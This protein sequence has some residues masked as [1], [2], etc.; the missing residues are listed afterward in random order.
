MS[1]RLAGCELPRPYICVQCRTGES[2]SAL[3]LLPQTYSKSCVCDSNRARVMEVSFPCYCTSH[4]VCNPRLQKATRGT[5]Y[6]QASSLR[7]YCCV[8]G[9][10]HFDNITH[11]RIETSVPR[12]RGPADEQPTHV[13]WMV[14]RDSD[15]DSA[16]SIC[17]AQPLTWLE[18]CSANQR[19]AAIAGRG[20]N[21]TAD[22]NPSWAQKPVTRTWRGAGGYKQHR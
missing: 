14:A 17:A 6:A 13:H 20:L 5:R 8:F 16:P 4:A 9:S 19:D 3:A 7:Y 12:T 11:C 15:R 18:C 1:R 22:G 2:L 10:K 21:S